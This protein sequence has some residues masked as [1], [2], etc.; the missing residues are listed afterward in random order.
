MQCEKCHSEH[1]GSY[2]SGRFCSRQCANSRIRTED[3]KRKISNSLIGDKKLEAISGKL[4]LF[5]NNIFYTTADFCSMK[6]AQRY[7]HKDL[8]KTSKSYY[9]RLCDFKFS[10]NSFS[11]EFDFG[12]IEEFGWYAPKNHGDNLE[13]ISR[14]HL[15]SIDFG[16]KNNIDPKT[17]SHP[18]N[19]RLIQHSKNV[20][21]GVDCSITLDELLEKIKNW[22]RKYGGLV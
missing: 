2:G 6:C 3:I 4:C 15:V 12:L 22:N 14:D 7:R 20:S 16:F 18:A 5:C 11:E 10:L 17:M 13:G 1:D 8:D 21:K 19:C 9:R